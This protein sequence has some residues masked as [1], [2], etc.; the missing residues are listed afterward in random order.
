MEFKHQPVLLKEVLEYITQKNDG[1]F[2]DGTLGGGGHSKALLCESK[3]K[4]Q[5]LKVIGIDQD[6]EAIFAA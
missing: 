1:F 4:S 5:K 2:V 6:L 3:A